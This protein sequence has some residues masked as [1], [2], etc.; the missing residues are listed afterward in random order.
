MAKIFTLICT[1]ISFVASA[2]FT[3]TLD[4]TI[5]VKGHGNMPLASAWAGGLNSAQYNT[6]DLNGDGSDDLVL[7]DRSGRKVITFLNLSNRYVYTPAY[8]NLFPSEILNWM[9]LRD[10]DGDGRK[11]LFTGDV[12]GIRVFTN[13]TTGDVPQWKHYRFFISPG[14][15]SDALLSEGLSG[16]INVQLQFD[17]LPS[18][19]DVDAD[20]DLD[21]F[22]MKFGSA[23]TIELHKNLSV[24]TYGHADSLKYDLATQAW[25]G[26]KEC[27]CGSMAF[28]GGPCKSPGAGKEDHAGGK[29]LLSLDI[30]GDSHRDLL[31]SEGECS[32]LYSLPNEGT[33]DAPV[34]NDFFPLYPAPY[35]EDLDFDGIRDLIVTPNV[36]SKEDYGINFHQSNWFY[37]NTGT[38]SNPT[39]VLSR[40]TF[41]QDE[42]IDLGD[43]VVPAFADVDADG[44][45]D[46]F[47]SNNNFPATVWMFENTGTS[48]DP[49]FTY[50]T[51][52]FA[53]LSSFFLR[54][55]KIQFF[56]ANQD[57]KID[58][59]FT[60]TR[61]ET[62]QN[63]L[64]YLANNTF[65]TYDFSGQSLRQIEF[66]VGP[67]ENILMTHVDD[68]SRPDLL[69]GK[70]SGAIEFW[71]NTGNLNFDLVTDQFLGLGS[72]SFR[73]N[74]TL[75]AADL[76]GDGKV[77][78]ILSDASGK[79][80][81]VSDYQNV[82]DADGA[83]TEIV[84]NELNGEHIS[85]NL[86][87]K[88]WPTSV[89][90]WGEARSAIVVGT[91]MGGVR[92]LRSNEVVEEEKT[93]IHVFPNPQIKGNGVKVIVNK[94]ASLTVFNAAGQ[95][96]PIQS[97][98]IPYQE[99]YIPLYNMAAGMYIMRFEVGDKFYTRKLVIH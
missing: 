87:G 43:N 14:N 3:Y 20:G 25:A 31:F 18:I 94:P 5:N 29:S 46:L 62:G 57:L 45:Y 93:S 70:S 12:F 28:N 72:N 51:D 54:N 38:D 47:L 8:E 22:C 33:I 2:Q 58:L 15:Y 4:T 76:N 67:S 53:G 77:D 17:D 80:R 59:V 97:P 61:F 11:D 34:V 35:Y 42:M 13:V 63:G 10:Y 39:F 83:I 52:D 44:D 74:Q 92:I 75:A 1:L 89:N 30:N 95:Q 90:L 79:L 82:S 41:L 66:T 50:K 65:V 21:I 16:L 56:D 27:G 68:D 71:K 26:V 9:L 86:G 37:K 36:F 96:L 73:V 91:S 78:L 19:S 60:A 84:H 40:K 55:L 48:T 69:K 99:T 88:V 7:F 6:M 23:G 49:E 64:F 98:L 81:I 32:T 85:L 24:E